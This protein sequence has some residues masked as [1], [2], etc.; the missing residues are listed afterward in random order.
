MSWRKIC[1]NHLAEKPAGRLSTCEYTTCAGITA[2]IPAAL[3]RPN[4]S[5]SAACNSASVRSSCGSVRW[6]SP[7]TKP[8]PGKCLPHDFMPPLFK[9]RCK[10]SANSVTTS[11]SQWK[12]RLPITAHCPQFKSSTGVNDK[13]TPQA[14]N[15]VANTQPTC[16]ARCLAASAPSL[17]QISPNTAIAG[18]RVKPSIKR[19]TRPPS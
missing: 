15:S 6:L 9:P 4:G 17:S 16:S 12:L 18:K 5:I 10:A 13:S 19:C 7:S 11:A 14:L 1:F 3:K 2:A 8:W